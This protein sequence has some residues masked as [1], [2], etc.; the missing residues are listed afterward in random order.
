M[1]EQKKVEI[2]LTV[3]FDAH[4]IIKTFKFSRQVFNMFQAHSVLESTYYIFRTLAMLSFSVM[5]V[6]PQLNGFVQDSRK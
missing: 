5:I 3:Q 6:T 1:R 2:K 4:F